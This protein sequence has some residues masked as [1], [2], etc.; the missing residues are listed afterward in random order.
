MINS[1][2][3]THFTGISNYVMDNLPMTVAE[4]VISAAFAAFVSVQKH[5]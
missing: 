5:L 3:L 2:C 4:Y 1:V